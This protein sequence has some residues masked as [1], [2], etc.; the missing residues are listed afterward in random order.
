[1]NYLMRCFIPFLLLFLFCSS[2]KGE[3]ESF[4]MGKKQTKN[5]ILPENSYYNPCEKDLLHF[6]DNYNFQDK[7]DVKQDSIKK[8]FIDFIILLSEESDTSQVEKAVSIL[9]EKSKENEEIYHLIEQTASDFLYNP[10]SELFNEELFIPFM[11]KYSESLLLNDFMRERYSF[12]LSM[13]L[14]NRKGSMASDFNFKMRDGQEN[15]LYGVDSH[16]DILLIFYDPDCLNCQQTIKAINENEKLQERV[17]NQNLEIIAIYSG[18]DKDLWDITARELPEE[19]IVGYESGQIE[20][21][22]IYFFQNL[23]SVYLLDRNK[24]V[25]KKDLPLQE[26]ESLG[27]DSL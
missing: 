6:W 19:W 25:I 11:R 5:R 18:D 26:I 8:S 22:D 13:A 4:E 2:F 27:E 7:E 23:P 15:S 17:K 14:K 1:M 10:E 12:F 9:I 3:E 20:E 16:C 21:E 24:T